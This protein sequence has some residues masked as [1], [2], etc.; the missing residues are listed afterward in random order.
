MGD[1]FRIDDD[2]DDNDDDRPMALQLRTMTNVLVASMS[3]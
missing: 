2:N 1:G 3:R